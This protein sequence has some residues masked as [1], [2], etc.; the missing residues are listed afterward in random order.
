MRF[1]RDDEVKRHDASGVAAL[2]KAWVW[3]EIETNLIH[4][5]WCNIDNILWNHNKQIPTNSAQR[6]EQSTRVAVPQTRT[7]PYPM[8]SLQVVIQPIQR[9]RSLVV[10]PDL[11]EG[12]PD[13]KRRVPPRVQLPGRIDDEILRILIPVRRSI[14][15]V[16]IS[17]KL[18]ASSPN[19]S[20]GGRRQ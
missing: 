5:R 11:D 16:W 9:H 13:L 4:L 7:H 14:C 18:A 3:N 8:L 1:R 12:N 19:P 10:V 15:C 6:P 20:T 2:L 17:P